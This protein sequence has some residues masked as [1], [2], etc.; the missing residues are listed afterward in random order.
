MAEPLSRVQL[1]RIRAGVERNP[2]TPSARTIRML[3]D[4]IDRWRPAQV[5]PCPLDPIYVDVIVCAANGQDVEQT[6]RT[7]RVSPETIKSRRKRIRDR[8]DVG[9]MEQVVAV[10]MA[11]GWVPGGAVRIPRPITAPLELIGTPG[12][13]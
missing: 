13:A 2:G 8:L 5:T 3:L 9:P 11:Q 6:A 4:E 7:L 10:A 12:G 1:D